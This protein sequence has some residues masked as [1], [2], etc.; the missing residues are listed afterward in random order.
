[1]ANAKI[2]I[3]AVEHS[4]PLSAGDL[5]VKK[6]N[7]QTVDEKKNSCKLKKSDPPIPFLSVCPLEIHLR[8]LQQTIASIWAEKFL[9]IC[10][11]TLSV[12]F[13]EL[14]YALGKL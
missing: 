1:M 7:M 5:T 3:A 13:R 9:D 4:F 8:D 14:R 2:K 11:R 10:P 6:Q 12:L